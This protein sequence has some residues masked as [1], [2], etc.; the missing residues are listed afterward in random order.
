MYQL[1]SVGDMMKL[2]ELTSSE[3][4]AMFTFNRRALHR[5]VFWARLRE[6]ISFKHDEFGRFATIDTKLEFEAQWMRKVTLHS[7]MLTK[8]LSKFYDYFKDIDERN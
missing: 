8:N 1:V 3:I 5:C 4:E 7:D 6:G 2:Q